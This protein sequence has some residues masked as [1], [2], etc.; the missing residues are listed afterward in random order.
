MKN[1]LP[2]SLTPMVEAMM[3]EC[4][5]LGI[6]VKVSFQVNE[7][8]LTLMAHWQEAEAEDEFDNND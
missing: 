2:D 8:T 6:G 4:R 5:E 7:N 3:K 1:L